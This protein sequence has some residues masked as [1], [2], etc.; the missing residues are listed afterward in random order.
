VEKTIHGLKADDLIFKTF[1]G[2]VDI[3]EH[4]GA[5]PGIHDLGDTAEQVTPE[6]PHRYTIKGEK[7]RGGMGR[8]LVAF[9]G[10]IGREIAI[11]ELL[12]DA[13]EEKGTEKTPSGPSKAVKARFLREARVTGQLEHPSIVPVYEIGQHPDGTCYYA[14]RM[15][16]GRNLSQAI[17]AS[18]DLN[19]RLKLLPHLHDL[20]NAIAYAH[21]KGVIHRD[22]KPENVMIGEFGETVVLDW[23]LAKVKGQSDIGAEKLGKG[24][25]LLR[26]AEAG[27]T[28]AGHA[29]GTPAYMPPEQAMGE[30]EEIDEKSDIY[31]LGAVLYEILTGQPPH[32]GLTA[33]DV[34]AKVLN[35]PIVPTVQR[36]RRIPKELGAV[37]EKA[38]NKRKEDRYPSALAIAS[39][40]ESYMAGGRVGAYEYSSWELAKKF[41]ARN[42]MVSALIVALVASLA[43]GMIVSMNARAK[44]KEARVSAELAQAKAEDNEKQ[45]HYQLSLSFTEKAQ[46]SY[47]E[48][49]F[50]S[51]RIFAA[52]ALVHSP[53]NPYGPY[54]FENIEQ[55]SD[56]NTKL[57]LVEAHSA[58]FQASKGGHIDNPVSFQR[59]DK[60]VWA[61]AFSH[62]GKMLASGGADKTIKL[63]NIKEGKMLATFSG[64]ESGVLS[65]AFSPDNK[66]LVSSSGDKSIRLWDVK[67]QKMVGSLIG[68]DRNAHSVSFFSDGK[69]LASGSSDNTIKL[70]NV[71]KKELV[72]TFYGHNDGVASVAVSPDNKTIASASWDKTIKIW[73]VEKHSIL[74]TLNGHNDRVNSVVFSPDGKMLASGS[75]DNTIKIWD[76]QNKGLVATLEGHKDR[77]TSLMFSPNG[78][79]LVSGSWDKTVKLWDIATKKI[80]ET[81]AGNK[82]AVWSVAFSPDGDSVVSGNEE[83][84]VIKWDIV[85]RKNIKS[86]TG[87]SAE[88]FIAAFSPDGR[89]L[90]SGSDDK[91]VKIWDIEGGKIIS[92]LTGHSN[93][94]IALAF[95]SNGKLLASSGLDHHIKIWDLEKKESI[96]DFVGHG[97]WVRSLAFSPKGD[98]LASA[99]DDRTIKIWDMS[100]RNLLDT[101][102]AHDAFVYFV[103]FSPKGEMIASA[104]DNA[105]KIW[106]VKTKKMIRELLGH[107]DRVSSVTFSSDG[108][109][110]A[111]SSK[112]RTIKLWEVISGRLL[113]TMEGHREWANYVKFS[114]AGDSLLSSSMDDTVG[115]WNVGAGE[116]LQMLRLS[117][118]GNEPSFHPDGKSFAVANDNDVMIFPIDLDHWKRDPRD[119]LREAERSAGMKLDGFTLRPMTPEEFEAY[120]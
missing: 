41:V 35:D 113:R 85:L 119:L 61:V 99:S 106:D 13:T 81:F 62:D 79:T 87:H 84:I 55:R 88:V 57:N 72:S 116:C 105:V 90:A 7:A 49:D 75:R 68:H 54:R 18:R 43:L 63:W 24:L 117:W 5:A 53:Y 100:S 86:L 59:H 4:P 52:A 29:F 15:V 78:K 21:S 33:F 67:E 94:I 8:L 46:R 73:S 36:D 82:S 103:A 114:P 120:Q 34:I 64:H 23:G 110:L 3:A 118:G 2:K 48:K 104:G 101:I 80:M 93:A 77:V 92:T 37:A 32:T 20:C 1:G 25:E 30:I 98:L 69:M 42:K 9:D 40:I 11:K 107:Q 39:D 96:S 111:S 56:R 60:F 66:M 112:D 74:A 108:K 76:M 97:N 95:S 47:D 6:T 28:V 19:E 50:L 58:L 12:C 91:T 71:N 27:K 31:S 38:L 14:M 109:L 45:V 17:K 83:G 16:K 115:I 51:S 22:I 10:H 65:V 89:L 44:E 102:I 70:W 26:D